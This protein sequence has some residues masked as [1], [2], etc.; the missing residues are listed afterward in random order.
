MVDEA[1]RHHT[2]VTAHCTG[3]EGAYQAILAGVECIEHG[4][5]LTQREIDLM[6]EKHIPLVSTLSVS[7]GVANIPGLPPYVH[8]KALACAEA[9]KK[10]IAMAR[11]AGVLIALGTDY[12]NSINT[13]YLQNGKEFEAMTRAGM[14]PM[15]AIH[16]GT[17]NAAKVMRN[18]Y[19]TGSLEAGKLADIVIVDGNPMEDILCLAD[20]SHVKMV[21][22]N[23]KLCKKEL[24]A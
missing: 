5:F 1:H 3:Y 12:S 7:L 16:A 24:S 15:E 10:T 13:P 18:D 23:G 19:E 9:N 20:A 11:K 2:Y 17:I 21:M 22:Q 6:A 4:V 14:T 8:Q